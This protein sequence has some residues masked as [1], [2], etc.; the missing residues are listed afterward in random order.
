M[1]LATLRDTMARIGIEHSERYWLR[2]FRR[3]HAKDLLDGGARLNQ[4]LQAGEWR[5]PAF[6][7]YLDTNKLEKAA[8]LEA[9][10]CES[11]SSSD[12]N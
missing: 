5:T 12:S 10:Q 3:G 9:H 1:A 8:V 7:K 2:D 6:L 11:S 4:I